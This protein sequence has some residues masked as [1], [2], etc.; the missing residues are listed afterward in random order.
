MR[1]LSRL[2]AQGSDIRHSYTMNGDAVNLGSC[3]EG[4]SKT[5]GVDIVVSESTRKLANDF[6]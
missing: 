2:A 5:Y 6:A 1:L 3:L 4:L